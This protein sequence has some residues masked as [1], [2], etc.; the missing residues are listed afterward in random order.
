M[1]EDIFPEEEDISCKLCGSNVGPF[2][3]VMG[4]PGT[5]HPVCAYCVRYID[6]LLNRSANLKYDLERAAD[7]D[8]RIQINT[9]FSNY[10]NKQNRWNY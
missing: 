6:T 5:S 10:M 7:D 3:Y 2:M 9:D 8:E 1:K 4:S